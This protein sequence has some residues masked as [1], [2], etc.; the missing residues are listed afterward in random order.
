MSLNVYS[1]SLRIPIL[2]AVHGMA[3]L[4]AGVWAS[5]KI[6]ESK[7]I[8]S[9]ISAGVSVFVEKLRDSAFSA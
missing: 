4:V 7:A 3:L 5:S 9:D 8:V 2:V 6:R 1:T